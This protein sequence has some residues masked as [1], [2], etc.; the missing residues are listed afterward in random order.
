MMVMEE[1]TA[2]S[3][4]QAT[5]G[6]SF[7]RHFTSRVVSILGAF[8]LDLYLA[9][10]FVNPQ[11]HFFNAE[12]EFFWIVAF[13]A[14]VLY[15]N[16]QT[17]TLASTTAL[18]NERAASIDKLFALSPI[19]V[20]VVGEVFWGGTGRIG[21]LSWRLHLI[22]LAFGIYG[23]TDYFSTDITNQRLRSRQFQMGAASN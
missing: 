21:E 19:V 6:K 7:M 9:I 15:A 5:K 10:L 11:Q 12:G 18:D 23:L 20:V 16:L 2:V 13:L 14:V 4:L 17:W 22:G 1:T 8:V 3:G